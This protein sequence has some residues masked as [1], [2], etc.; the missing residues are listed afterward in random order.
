M[1]L[2][3]KGNE[4]VLRSIFRWHATLTREVLSDYEF[5]LILGIGV[6]L[7]I[8]L[9]L[10]IIHLPTGVLE[11]EITPMLAPVLSVATFSAV[12][13]NGQCFS[14]YMALYNDCMK[15]D[16][17][18]KLLVAELLADFS[19]DAR[20]RPNVLAGAKYTLAAIF[21]FYSSMDD[22]EMT[23][24]HWKWFG[25]D[26]KGLLTEEEIEVVKAFPGHKVLLLLHW[27]QRVAMAAVASEAVGKKYSPPEKSAITGRIFSLLNSIA[28]DLRNVSN[29]LNLPIPFPYF[30]LLNLLIFFSLMVAGLCCCIFA[31]RVEATT[32]C[33]AIGPLA[34][35]AF[36]LIGMRTLSTALSDP[37]GTDDVDFP[38]CDF[39]RHIYDH[40]VAILQAPNRWCPVKDG[41]LSTA[42]EFSVSQLMC[43]CHYEDE[44]MPP[45]APQRIE[46]ELRKHNQ[47]PGD[48]LMHGPRIWISPEDWTTALRM[49]DWIEHV[50]GNGLS[51]KI[52]DAVK[53]APA[54]APAL[55]AP[56]PAPAPTPAPAPA[57]VADAVLMENLKKMDER[58]GTVVR[59]AEMF[60]TSLSQAMGI[61]LELQQVAKTISAMASAKEEV[62]NNPPKE[63]SEP[64]ELGGTELRNRVSAPK[65]TEKKKKKEKKKDV[66]DPYS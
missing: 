53:Q 43:P 33:V 11:L 14:R 19:F 47:G 41:W 44:A 42:Q 45:D 65:E 32:Y 20:L 29:T 2:Y 21:Y 62:S 46:K 54:P 51:N 55:T 39:M 58:L 49:K 52:E 3:Y 60:S 27:T 12:F 5:W 7:T 1:V 59:A 31:A 66:A 36:V 34:V 25:P 38:H 16:T 37:F 30:H 64:D 56:A 6:S 9:D 48:E 35:I 50:Q 22:R 24:E 28:A 15:V 10:E 17:N 40:V 4:S 63:S 8:L 57:P 18:V 23:D 13:Y 61:P 26:A